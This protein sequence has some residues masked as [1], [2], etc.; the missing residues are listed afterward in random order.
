MSFSRSLLLSAMGFEE[1]AAKEPVVQGSGS[2]AG[3]KG[4]CPAWLF[5]RDADLPANSE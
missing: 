5:C 3:S 4:V 1:D 2:G